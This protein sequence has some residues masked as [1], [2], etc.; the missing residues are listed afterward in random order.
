[1][2]KRNRAIYLPAK[3]QR[4]RKEVGMIREGALASISLEG[5]YHGGLADSV[6]IVKL[7]PWVL[8]HALL[9]GQRQAR[10]LILRGSTPCRSMSSSTPSSPISLIHS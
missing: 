5:Q 4:I 8:R 3:A 6:N 10:T 9:S 2:T 7:M 1:M